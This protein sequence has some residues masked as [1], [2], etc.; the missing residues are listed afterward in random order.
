MNKTKYTMTRNKFNVTIYKKGQR[1]EA[2]TDFKKVF[3][4]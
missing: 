3:R 2:G 1:D 4:F